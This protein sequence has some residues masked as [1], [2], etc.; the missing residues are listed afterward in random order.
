MEKLP[1]R[2]MHGILWDMPGHT[3]GMA[4]G[5]C[6]VPISNLAS[7]ANCCENGCGELKTEHELQVHDASNHIGQLR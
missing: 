3:F 2:W 4:L 7:C 6:A 1:C 5:T